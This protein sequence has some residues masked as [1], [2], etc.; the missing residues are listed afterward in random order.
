MENDKQVFL[1]AQK[2]AA[3]DDPQAADVYETGTVATIFTNVKT[4]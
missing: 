4:P 1:V 3:V 2:D